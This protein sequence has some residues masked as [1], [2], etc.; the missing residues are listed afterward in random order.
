LLSKLDV[1]VAV[2]TVLCLIYP[3]ST[4]EYIE[5]VPWG[6]DLLNNYVDVVETTRGFPFKAITVKRMMGCTLISHYK[7][8]V[9]WGLL[10]NLTL[11]FAVSVAAE[12]FLESKRRGED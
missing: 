8:E 2:L 7:Y 4:D 9:H 11:V 6:C 1:A 5:Q 10:P 3:R 12:E